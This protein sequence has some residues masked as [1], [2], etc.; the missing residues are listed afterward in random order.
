MKY[1]IK[2]CPALYQI[3]GMTNECLGTDYQCENNPYCILKKIIELCE[4]AQIKDVVKGKLKYHS[5]SK[6]KL[7][8]QILELLEIMVIENE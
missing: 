5:P 2:N 4:D 3:Q 8:R 7:G 1:I 6:A